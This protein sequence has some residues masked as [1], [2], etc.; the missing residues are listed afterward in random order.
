MANEKKPRNGSYLEKAR[1]NVRTRLKRKR[2]L[3]IYCPKCSAPLIKDKN[4][5]LK[6]VTKNGEEE[7]LEL[8][9]YLN[10]YEAEHKYKT[11]RYPETGIEDVKC[12]HCNQSIVH[13]QVRCEI[14]GSLTAE[15]SVAAVQF[16]V[17]FLICL[18]EGC[19]WHRIT[20]EDELR[21]IQDSSREW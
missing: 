15:L 21:L 2:F 19:L 3:H 18:K 10:V 9:V 17:P 6:A 7:I 4:V 8:F 20:S 14:C 16:R 13:A 12:P 5:R 1:Y 11:V